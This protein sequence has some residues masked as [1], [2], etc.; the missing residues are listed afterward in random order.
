MIKLTTQDKPWMMVD[1][2]SCKNNASAQVAKEHVRSVVANGKLKLKIKK[3]KKILI[4]L[5][6]QKFIKL[7]KKNNLNMI[8][9]NNKIKN[10]NYKKLKL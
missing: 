4:K 8:N 1:S 7:I 3:I 10:Q 9:N 2:W 6:H 5:I